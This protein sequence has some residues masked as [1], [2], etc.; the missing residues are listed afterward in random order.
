MRPGVYLRLINAARFAA[1]GLSSSLPLQLVGALLFMYYR[2]NIFAFC[3]LYF[4]RVFGPRTAATLQGL[5]LTLVAPLNY[6][7]APAIAITHADGNDFTSLNMLMAC[8][9]VPFMLVILC[10][11]R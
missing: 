3:F 2:A 6:L 11:Y 8:S 5:T 9:V 1:P 10:M 7:V 4:L